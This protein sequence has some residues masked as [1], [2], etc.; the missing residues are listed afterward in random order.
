MKYVISLVL[1]TRS[2]EHTYENTEQHNIFDILKYNTIYSLIFFFFTSMS[3][4]VWGM[5]QHPIWRASRGK[6]L[7]LMCSVLFRYQPINIIAR[8]VWAAIFHYLSEAKNHVM[9]WPDLQPP[10]FLLSNHYHVCPIYQHGRIT[11]FSQQYS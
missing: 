10:P 9:L 7:A 2:I 3:G 1:Y 11:I 4:H 8:H 6:F 5:N